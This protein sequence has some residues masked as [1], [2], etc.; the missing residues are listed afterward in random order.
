MFSFVYQYIYKPNLRAGQEFPIHAKTMDNS[1][2]YVLPIFL[3]GNPYTYHFS[4]SLVQKA[5]LV[6]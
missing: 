2:Y 6:S 4:L 1:S 5:C 3:V